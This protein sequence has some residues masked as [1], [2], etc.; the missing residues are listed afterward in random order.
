MSQIIAPYAAHYEK[1]SP[2]PITVIEGW[3]LGF[4]L[5]NAIK[6]IARHNHKGSSKE[7]LEKAVWYLQRH[8]EVTN[9]NTK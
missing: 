9:A 1:V 4:H 6:Y 3:G 8:L 2:E 7:D 5:G